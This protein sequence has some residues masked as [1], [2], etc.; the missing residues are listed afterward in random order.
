M[1]HLVPNRGITQ[2]GGEFE[3]KFGGGSQ[4]GAG[5]ND[6]GLTFRRRFVTPLSRL[7]FRDIL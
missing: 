5:R 7:D 2:W 1:Y 6:Q 4:P 3:T